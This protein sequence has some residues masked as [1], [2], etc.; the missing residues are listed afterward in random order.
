MKFY[1]M[2]KVIRGSL[3]L[4][5]TASL[6]LA[7]CHEVGTPEGVIESAAQALKDN[8]LSDFRGHLTQE[9]QLQFQSPDAIQALQSQLG[10]FESLTVGDSVQLSHGVR[11]GRDACVS[12]FHSRQPGRLRVQLHEVP[13]LGREY[14]EELFHEIGAA[15]VECRSCLDSSG[16]VNANHQACRVSALSIRHP[17][18]KRIE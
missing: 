12:S 9:A 17:M 4:L 13:I 8:R 2:K 3:G 11:V 10:S 6:L 14:G 7:S 18:S 5:V 15:K 1:V 16:V